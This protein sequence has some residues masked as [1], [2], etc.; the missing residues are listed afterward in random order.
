MPLLHSWLSLPPPSHQHRGTGN[1][2]RGQSITHWHSFPFTLFPC[3]SVG[4]L[5]QETVLHY[6][7]HCGSFPW[8]VVPFKVLQHGSPMGTQVLPGPCSHV[9]FPQSHNLLWASLC[10]G[11]GSTMGCRWIC[12]P[13]H[14]VGLCHTKQMVRALSQSSPG[15]RRMVLNTSLGNWVW[16]LAPE[17]LWFVF[18]WTD[19]L[20][21]W[22]L[23]SLCIWNFL[24]LV[25]YKVCLFFIKNVTEL[26]KN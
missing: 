24:G 21:L 13:A 15:A 11:V 23:M 10:C 6:L 5:T 14:V 2:C 4:S 3:S 12:T 25:V 20:L 18:C 26:G 1:V 19:L 8:A 9:G 17:W 22:A 7:L 16:N